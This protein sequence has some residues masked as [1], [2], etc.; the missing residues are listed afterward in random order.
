MFDRYSTINKRKM[1]FLL[2]VMKNHNI[3]AVNGDYEV[4]F[5]YVH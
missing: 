1:I 2:Q 4:K 3:V 5:E